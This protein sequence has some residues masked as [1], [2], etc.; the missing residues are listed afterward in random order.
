MNTI[1]LI[2]KL[3]IKDGFL[4]KGINLEGLRKLG[5]PCKFAEKYYQ[6][7]ID[8]IIF[9]DVT[10]TLYGNNGLKNIISNLSK[11]IFIPITVGGGIRSIQDIEKTFNN[12]AD[13]VMLNSAVVKNIDLLNN[14]SKIFGS[15]N[16]TVNVEYSFIG[17]EPTIFFEYGRQK[18]NINFYDWLKKLEQCGAGEII[19]T[20]INNEGT[21]EGYDEK[22]LEKANNILK[23]PFTIHGGISNTNQL[24]TITKKYN[25]ISGLALSSLLH[26][27]Y[28]KFIK[29]KNFDFEFSSKWENCK[30][31]KIK[32][33]L[34]KKIKVRLP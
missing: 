31:K 5:D 15:A 11:N 34:N 4:V 1:R 16:L 33:E 9:H 7:G 2:A 13:R 17:N 26:Y 30:I 20:C 10:A 6:D 32:K 25:N 28:I 14:A 24:K 8:E 22:I 19:F 27:N 3:D 21:G 23:I 12:G 18:A 29:D